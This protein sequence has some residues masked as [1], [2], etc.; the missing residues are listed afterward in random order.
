MPR[1]TAAQVI[2]WDVAAESAEAVAA[3]VRVRGAEALA[4]AVDVISTDAVTQASRQSPEVDVVVNNAGVVT[5]APLTEATEAGIRRTFEVNA[6]APYWV[7]RA[8]LPGMVERNAGVVVTVAADR[9]AD[10]QTSRTGR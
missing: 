6:L 1:G 10:E 8:F 7:T 9:A 5:G 2:V 3:E 4:V